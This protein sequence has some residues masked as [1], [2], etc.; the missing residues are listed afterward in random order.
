MKK[1]SIKLLC[2]FLIATILL[3]PLGTAAMAC[4]GDNVSLFCRIYSNPDTIIALHFLLYPFLPLERLANEDLT[5]GPSPKKIQSIKISHSSSNR[6]S[7]EER[8]NNSPAEKESSPPIKVTGVTLNRDIMFLTAGG[9]TGA[10]FATITP[11]DSTNKNV[12]WSSSNAAA[13]SVTDG[14][15]TPLSAGSTIIIATTVDGGFIANCNVTVVAADNI[16]PITIDTTP[17]DGMT[18][19]SVDAPVT[20]NF[21]ELIRPSDAYETIT[22]KDE[23]ENPISVTKTVYNNLL[24]LTPTENLAHLTKYTVTIPSGAIEDEA[25]NDLASTLRFSFN[26]RPL[27]EL[28]AQSK[29]LEEDWVIYGNLYL[30]GGCL[31]LNGHTL[32]VKGNL[33][34]S[35]GIMSVNSGTLVTAGD[36]RLQKENV[37]ADGTVTYSLSKGFI[38]MLNDTDNVQ[39]GRDFV[40]DSTLSHTNY[41]KAG[42]LEVK[43]DFAQKQSTDESGN[44]A[45]NKNFQAG[46]SHKVLL[47]GT[48]QQ[49]VSFANPGSIYSKFNTLEITNSSTDGVGFIS[50]IV[51]SHLFDHHQN[52]FHITMPSSEFPDYD[53]DGLKDDQDPF[54]TL[55]LNP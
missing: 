48:K 54:P 5:Y 46:G 42:T 27:N 7:R 47:S 22:M 21:S 51:V 49:T 53:G 31:N 40:M 39:V 19:I 33:I 34:Q 1:H 6:S 16:P 23:N 10:L 32:K 45:S 24:T 26:T 38:E 50:K 3:L 2:L 30:N 20:I 11:A 35:G 37:Q 55:N 25:G 12:I 44:K 17:R 52:N 29:T 14:V 15:V 13:A 36:Y 4:P 28:L 9:Q 43:G 41:L 18:D 8:E